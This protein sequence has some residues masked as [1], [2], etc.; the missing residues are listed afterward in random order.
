MMNAKLSPPPRLAVVIPT[1]DRP[2][3]LRRT[4][5]S[6]AEQSRRPDVIAIASSG[7]MARQYVEVIGAFPEIRIDHRHVEPGSASGQRNI[8]LNAVKEESD[9]I[10]FIDDDVVLDPTSI[11]T[12][13]RFFETAPADVGGAGFNLRN[14][15][16]PET[17]RKWAL[18]PVKTLYGLFV[19]ESSE[20]GKVLR[21]G[22]P[23]PIYPA[24]ET[25][26]VDWLETLAVVFRKKVLDEFQ[27]IESYG[28]YDYVGFVDFTYTVG[29]RYKLYVVS[30]A[31]VT[32]YAGPIRNS[33][34]LGKKQILSRIYFVRKHP[35]LSL[36]RCMGALV[37]HTAF[38][39]A[40]GVMLRD[41][42]YFQ[43]ARGNLAGFAQVAIGRL[44]PA[45]GG[46][47]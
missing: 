35:E 10:A 31:W 5:K 47:R 16:A 36:P 32:H 46:I 38:N 30:D 22:F 21:S 18:G 26:R 12:M 20:K 44:N 15:T 11:E 27:W 42:G 6:L 40:V 34:T 17:T 37:L 2:D 8:G 3:S 7:A 29:K 9:L 19:R 25:M 33:Y 23:T 1:R 4:L 13:L 45:G 24:S 28:G 39:V 43:R 14:M 41:R